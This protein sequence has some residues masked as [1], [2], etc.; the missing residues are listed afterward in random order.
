MSVNLFN[1]YDLRMEA[2]YI[3]YPIIAEYVF[4]A[5]RILLPTLMVYLIGKKKYLFVSLVTVVILLQFSVDG[6]KSVFF[7]LILSIIG[8]FFYKENRIK[9][10]PLVLF[11][12]NLF[13]LAE[14]LV[15]KSYFIASIFCRRVLLVPGLLNLCYYDFFSK[16]EV[17][18]FRSGP[19]RRLGFEM[20]HA[21]PPDNLIGGLYFGNFQTSANN[22]LFSDAYCNLGFIGVF[23]LPF[24][25]MFLLKILEGCAHN[26]EMK[27]LIAVLITTSYTLNNST[28]FT[29]LLSH[30]FIA[31][32]IL[33]YCFPRDQ[34][35]Q[36]NVK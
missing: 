8:C 23:I 36:I 24:F 15:A 12:I 22:G 1:V 2:R 18:L 7:A 33:L 16:H 20:P 11:M 35:Q 19:L 29:V 30:G 28:I 13:A 6:S 3:N 4:S 31:C 14:F 34:E 10:I 26:I 17:N 9:Y 32:C 25:I 27:Y 5:S 21:Y